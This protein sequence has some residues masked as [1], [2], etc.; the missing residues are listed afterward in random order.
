MEMVRI[1]TFIPNKTRLTMFSKTRTFSA[2]IPHVIQKEKEQ[3]AEIRTGR[4]IEIGT[5]IDIGTT[6][7]TAVRGKR[8]VEG[9]QRIVS[10]IGVMIMRG[11]VIMTVTESADTDIDHILAQEESQGIDLSPVPV[12]APARKANEQVVLIWH[13]LVLLP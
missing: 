10:A 5:R 11:I 6:T 2:S 4:G 12:L 3:K 9:E 1:T 13:H 7:G 8:E